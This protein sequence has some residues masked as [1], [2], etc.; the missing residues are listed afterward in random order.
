MSKIVH[1]M[2]YGMTACMREGPPKDWPE[3]HFWSGDWA[4]VT[5]DDCLA[6]RD[7]IQTFTVSADGKSITCL[8]CKRT[9]YHPDDVEKKY[10]GFCHAFH[11][12]IWPPARAWWIK[13]PPAAEPGESNQ[14]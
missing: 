6:G 13:N 8:R 9:S 2:Q 14:L 3:G 11:D 1:Y 5:C 12:D 10:C 4:D 7:L